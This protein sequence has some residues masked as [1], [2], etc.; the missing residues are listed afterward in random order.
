VK[1]LIYIYIILPVI[2]NSIGFVQGFYALPACPSDNNGIEINRVSSYIGK[3]MR[4]ENV[5]FG[6]KKLVSVS[7]CRLK[8]KYF[9]Y[10][11]SVRTPQRTQCALFRRTN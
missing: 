11:G 4:V 7:A 1:V 3:I 2:Q 10:K 5:V 6:K 9:I 8:L